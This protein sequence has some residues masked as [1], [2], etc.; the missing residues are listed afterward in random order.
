MPD[1]SL[2]SRI[3][4]ASSGSF[5]GILKD[6][7]AFS[8]GDLLYLKNMDPSNLDYVLK[9]C[10]IIAKYGGVTSHMSCVCR[11]VGIPA[12]VYSGAD[13]LIGKKVCFDPDGGLNE[14]N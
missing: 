12:I 13:L 5:C 9:S 6:K 1:N 11:E 10:G 4:I 14:Y 8:D 3:L 2:E 7:S